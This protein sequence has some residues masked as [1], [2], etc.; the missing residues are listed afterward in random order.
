MC[1]RALAKC[2][3]WAAGSR[4][5]RRLKITRPR[6]LRILECSASPSRPGPQNSPV[7]RGAPYRDLGPPTRSPTGPPLAIRKER[8]Q[9]LVMVGRAVTVSERRFQFGD[10]ILNLN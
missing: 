10:H 9:R 7:P 1:R 5:L 2:C 6:L 4:P 3:Q 8:P